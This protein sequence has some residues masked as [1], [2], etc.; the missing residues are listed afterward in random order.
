MASMRK[1]AS[2]C[3]SSSSFACCA[4]RSRMILTKPSP[5]RRRIISPEP[6]NRDPSF[7]RCHLSSSLRPFRAALDRSCS[8]APAARS[9]GVKITSPSP[10]RISCSEYP[11]RRSAPM[12]QLITFPV[13]S[14]ANTAKS[15]ALSTIRRKR[16]ASP[17]APVSEIPSDIIGVPPTS[18]KSQ[19]EIGFRVQST[20]PDLRVF[21]AIGTLAHS[22][23]SPRQRQRVEHDE[24]PRTGGWTESES[25]IMNLSQL[26]LFAASALAPEGL[27]YCLDF[28]TPAEERTLI[29]HLAQ[30]EL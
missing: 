21:A 16:S 17:G 2:L 26:S 25:T 3:A 22:S 10:P 20:V 28:V 18:P 24:R 29:A 15:V 14:S 11:V 6:Q 1:R 27:E 5:V 30:L 9:S 7:R 13:S 12:F 8:G 4:V 23:R 19:H